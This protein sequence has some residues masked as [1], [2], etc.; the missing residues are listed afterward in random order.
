MEKKNVVGVIPNS[1]EVTTKDTK[2]FFASF[3]SRD[4]AYDILTNIWRGFPDNIL[5][6]QVSE[7]FRNDSDIVDIGSNG[8]ARTD[9]R[10]SRSHSIS[11]TR[12]ADLA[13]TD[14]SANDFYILSAQSGT[15]P[16][17]LAGSSALQP[18]ASAT[19]HNRI[20]SEPLPGVNL[21]KSSQ[22]LDVFVDKGLGNLIPDEQT[23]STEPQS[24]KNNTIYGDANVAT[25][26]NVSNLSIGTDVTDNASKSSLHIV[27]KKHRISVPKV[28]L[29]KSPSRPP[30]LL[31]KQSTSSTSV[32]IENSTIITST[33]ATGVLRSRG[34][35]EALPDAVIEKCGCDERHK[36]MIKCLDSDIPLNLQKTF[37]LLY[38]WESACN[39]FIRKFWEGP[40]KHRDIKGYDW[41]EADVVLEEPTTFDMDAEPVPISSI[42]KGFHRRLFY[43][44]PVTNPLAPPKTRC[45][46]HD[47]IQCNDPYNICIESNG[48]TPDVPSGTCF[49]TNT[50]ISLRYRARDVTRI[51]VSCEINYIKSTWV[52][53]KWT[54]CFFIT[55]CT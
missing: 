43:I 18:S 30:V 37:T 27:Q 40:G 35:L 49:E 6:L 48:Q 23:T 14:K 17:L 10:K 24:V 47:R 32:S 36:K 38:G 20:S 12:S 3:I 28:D 9:S 55:I 31:H 13:A 25:H 2:Y 29:S 8:A 11:S 21:T 45:F 42:K 22:K 52:K 1:I 15:K 34:S 4:A 53:R 51:T 16:D 46:L 44:V 41:H 54:I 19:T 26:S 39:G 7:E 33:K 50:L 5:K